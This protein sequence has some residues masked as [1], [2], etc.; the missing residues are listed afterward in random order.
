MVYKFTLLS[1][2]SD[3]FLRVIEIDSEATFLDFHKAI[4]KACGY[5]DDQMT[6]FFIC[7]AGWNKGTEITLEDMDEDSEVDSYIMADTKLS[8]FCEE[9]KQ[10]L[11][12][13]FDPLSGRDFFIE[14][15]NIL[16]K[17]D[18][19]EPVCT[20][21]EGEAPEQMRDP[22]FSSS[23]EDYDDSLADINDYDDEELDGLTITD[24]IPFRDDDIQ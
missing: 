24:G 8:Q 20:V 23:G 4:L 17:K 15:T 22:D 9:K 14:L 10:R 3:K 7:D 18:I 11:L 13:E 19:K 12:Y 6:S 5:K 21:S 2:E 1:D 16:F